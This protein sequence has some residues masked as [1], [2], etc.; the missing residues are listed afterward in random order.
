MSTPS[1]LAAWA[2]RSPDE[3][4]VRVETIWVNWY[5][6]NQPD[7]DGIWVRPV[8]L[9]EPGG[10]PEGWRYG[11]L[12]APPGLREVGFGKPDDHPDHW[13]FHLLYFDDARRWVLAGTWVSRSRCRLLNPIVGASLGEVHEEMAHL[14][15]PRTRRYEKLQGFTDVLTPL[16]PAEIGFLFAMGNLWATLPEECYSPPPSVSAS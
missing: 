12:V 4:L 14:T 7:G 13:A 5:A 1:S 16:V 11:A 15:M 9:A 3:V 6:S 10:L 8:P 2:T